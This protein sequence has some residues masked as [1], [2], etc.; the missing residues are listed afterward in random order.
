MAGQSPGPHKNIVAGMAGRGL[1]F[2]ILSGIVT[3]RFFEDDSL[4]QKIVLSLVAGVVFTVLYEL[5]DRLSK[6]LGRRKKR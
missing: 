2:A 1:V 6:Q 5:V 4:L 3:G